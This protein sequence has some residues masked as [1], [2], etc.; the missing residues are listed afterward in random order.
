MGRLRKQ[1]QIQTANS[2]NV[3]DHASNQQHDAINGIAW[4]VVYKRG[5]EDPT[6]AC[7]RIL[8]LSEIWTAEM[9]TAE[10]RGVSRSK[11]GS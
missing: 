11:S 9:Q 5:L 8:G 7:G 4:R 1:N 3:Q 2:K 10:L 6:A